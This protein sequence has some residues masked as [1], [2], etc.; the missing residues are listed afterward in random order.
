LGQYIYINPKEKLIMMA[1]GN[2]PKPVG[3]QP[4]KPEIFFNTIVNYPKQ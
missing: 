1:T 2:E 3:K 4:I